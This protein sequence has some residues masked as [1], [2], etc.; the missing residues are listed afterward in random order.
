[1]GMMWVSL[2]TVT[3]STL[4]AHFRV[5][6]AALFSLIRAIGASIGTS[7][8][9]SILVRSSQINYI[10]MRERVTEFSDPL[11]FNGLTAVWNYDTISGLL[12]LQRM[13]LT[14][15]HLLAF[16]NDFVFLVFVAFVAM[17]LIFLLRPKNKQPS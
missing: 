14:E 16:L 11:R 7:I 12:A 17:P 3:F 9:V 8:V 2:T 10:E 5:E 4:S 15:A 13:V 6:A 1:M